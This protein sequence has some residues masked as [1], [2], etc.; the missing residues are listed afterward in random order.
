MAALAIHDAL[1]GN[2]WWN[3]PDSLKALI[4]GDK[5]FLYNAFGL[6]AAQDDTYHRDPEGSTF[7]GGMGG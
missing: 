2:W 7:P 5:G 4:D 1:P 6:E 3:L